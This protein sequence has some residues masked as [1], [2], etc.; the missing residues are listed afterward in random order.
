MDHIMSKANQPKMNPIDESFSLDSK[1]YVDLMESIDMEAID[2]PE[3]RRS[4]FDRL[5]GDAGLRQEVANLRGDVAT[6]DRKLTD[7]M[8]LLRIVANRE[9]EDINLNLN[10]IDHV[11]KENTQISNKIDNTS[12]RYSRGEGLRCKHCINTYKYEKS[13]RKHY[14]RDHPFE[15]FDNDFCKPREENHFTSDVRS[16]R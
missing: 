4:S 7:I 12:Y 2:I 5:T 11:L 1:D 8:D 16:M 6:L 13:M 3:K 14:L 10:K 15:N 9:V